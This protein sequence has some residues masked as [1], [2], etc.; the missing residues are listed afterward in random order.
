VQPQIIE[1]QAEELGVDPK[2]GLL[3][4]GMLV[5][6]INVQPKYIKQGQLDYTLPYLTL[7]Y[8]YLQQ[9]LEMLP[10]ILHTFLTPPYKVYIFGK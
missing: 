4:F 8:L 9:M 10:T 5:E 1:P 7:P 6:L 3:N 2:L